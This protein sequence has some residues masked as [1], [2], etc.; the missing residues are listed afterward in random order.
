MSLVKVEHHEFEMEKHMELCHQAVIS[1]WDSVTLDPFSS[2]LC[3]DYSTE[4]QL[5]SSQA[6]DNFQN[7]T[8]VQ[9]TPEILRKFAAFCSLTMN[10]KW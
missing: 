7:C 1:F 2:K 3:S 9:E 8:R 5:H 10:N 4:V 6:F